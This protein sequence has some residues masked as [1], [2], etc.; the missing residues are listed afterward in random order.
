MA[1]ILFAVPAAAHPGMGDNAAHDTMHA[2]GGFE[3]TLAA[4][5]VVLLA[6]LVGRCL[7][8]PSIRRK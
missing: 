6:W 8:S 2:V 5:A 1:T 3:I 7:R 4:L